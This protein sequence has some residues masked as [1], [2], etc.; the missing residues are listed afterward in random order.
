[1][2]KNL[3][4]ERWHSRQEWLLDQSVFKPQYLTNP[5]KLGILLDRSKMGPSCFH[6]QGLYYP[7]RMAHCSPYWKPQRTMALGTRFVSITLS[8]RHH[9]LSFIESV[10]A[11]PLL[12]PSP[13]EAAE[14]PGSP[15]LLFF[16]SP[17]PTN[18][19]SLLPSPFWKSF[20]Y[21][22]KSWQGCPCFLTR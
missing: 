9:S 14:N 13:L 22:T 15:L 3:K 17:I 7:W 6:A 16:S 11:P 1:M 2:T 12:Q 19:P 5:I 8:P 10:V 21:E 20:T 4:T 18:V